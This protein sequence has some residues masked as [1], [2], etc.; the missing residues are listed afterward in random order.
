MT[1]DKPTSP[2]SGDGADRGGLADAILASAT[3]LAVAVVDPELRVVY[4]NPGAERVF[5]LGST[6]IV[7]QQI[8]KLQQSRGLA[9]SD[10]EEAL[11]VADRDGSARLEVCNER[12]APFSTYDVSVQPLFHEGERRGWVV[13]AVDVSRRKA[14]ET[15]SRRREQQL[16]ATL[17]AA[18]DAILL[19]DDDGRISQCNDR[20]LQMIGLDADVAAA[21]DGGGMLDL[22]ARR[23]EA[24]DAFRELVDELRQSP[25]EHAGVLRTIEGQTYEHHSCPL[26][27]SDQPSGR[28]WTFRDVTERDRSD[29]ARKQLETEA[30]RAERLQSLEVMAGGIA[31]DFNNLLTGV[32]GHAEVAQLR[33]KPDHPVYGM[34]TKIRTAADR[35]ATLSRQML[36]FVGQTTVR[37]EDVDLASFLEEL[38]EDLGIWV[39]GRLRL[40]VDLEATSEVR[41]DPV[42]L[43]EMLHQ[44]VTNAVEATDESREERGTLTVRLRTL[45]RLPE[46]LV[47]DFFAA[48]A[49]NGPFAEIRVVDNGEGIPNQDL[50]R[51]FEPFYS[52]RFT[53]RGL[54]LASVL[55]IVRAHSGGLAVYSAPHQ[56]TV[57]SIL[58]PAKTA[59]SESV[60]ADA[61]SRPRLVLIVDDE[62]LVRELG[63]E[64]VSLLGWTP[65]TAAD[66]EQAL[67]I[68]RRHQEDIALAV[69]DLTMPGLSGV[70]VHRRIKERAPGLPV[71]IASGYSESD[72]RDRFGVVQ[73]DGFLSKPF[74]VAQIRELLERHTTPGD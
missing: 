39:G 60:R 37:P 23:L 28:V 65:V 11:S 17:D 47:F 71:V 56:E 12:H 26:V 51:I 62:P 32:L 19:I 72:V 31:H 24:Q 69:V 5:G 58:L 1:D 22:L 67:E 45:P 41:A 70:E 9:A 18:A 57:F 33:L 48:E 66:G 63:E 49:R 16:T 52:T 34:L 6:D 40:D 64:I 68:A 7:G 3:D 20:F 54:G 8:L 42:Q 44:L 25:E 14:A 46:A 21:S 74:E 36:T 35:A 10:L 55:G 30:R 29:R 4:V 27:E 43:K 50:D 53:G 73:P 15:G 59:E 13:I 2:F 61:A 38:R